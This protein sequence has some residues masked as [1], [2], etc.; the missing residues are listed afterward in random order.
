MTP[1][2]TFWSLETELGDKGQA[3]DAERHMCVRA[4][5]RVCFVVVGVEH[6][7]TSSRLL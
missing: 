4:C 1:L 5:E 2:E 7:F 6:A 3:G